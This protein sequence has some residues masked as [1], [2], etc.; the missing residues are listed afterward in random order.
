MLDWRLLRLEKGVMRRVAGSAALRWAAL[1][2]LAALMAA[3]AALA[4]GLL[5]PGAPARGIAGLAA[6]ACQGSP[7]RTALFCAA[8][9]AA[10]LALEHAAARLASSAASLVKRRAREDAYAKLLRL[11][12]SWE[13]TV[14][15][16]EA[17]KI[18]GEGAEKLE[19][20]VGRYAPQLLFALAAPLTLFALLVPVCWQSA[21]AML[22]CVP[23]MPLAI[24]A[25]MRSARREARAYWDSFV[26]LGG[27]F[28]DAVRGL[29][30]LKVY[31]SDGLRQKS[32]AQAGEAF[33]EATMALLRKQLGSVAVMEGVTY[34]GAAV[35]IAAA[36][37]QAASG[38]ASAPDALLAALLAVDFFMPMRRLG[39]YFHTAMGAG[40]AIDSLF[41]L[42]D[43]PEPARGERV[44]DP[45]D[46]GFVCEGVGYAYPDGRAGLRGASIEAPAGSYIGVTG[47]SGAGKSTLA[48]VLSGRLAG[49]TGS[50]RVGGVEL[51]DL[52]PE[53]LHET[54]TYVSRRSRVFKG[55]LRSNLE[56]GRADATDAEMWT[57]LHRCRLDAFAVLY[58]GLDTPVEEG[59]SN[60][61]GGQRQR[62][63]MARA[64]LHDTPVY[65]LDE[66]T[67]N[68]DAASEK[69][70]LEFVQ[71]LSITKTVVVISHRLAAIKWADRIYVLQD[72]AVAESGTHVGLI[73]AGGTYRRLWESQHG[74]E[75]FA[76]KAEGGILRS[77]QEE[78][79]PKPELD[80]VASVIARMPAKMAAVMQSAVELMPVR[81]FIA[82]SE[83][84]QRGGHP[85][86]I[87][88]GDGD[89]GS[90]GAAGGATEPGGRP[91]E[92]QPRK[93]LPAAPPRR[94]ALAV[95]AGL[96]RQTGEQLPR[97]AL[98]VALGSLA[99]LAA[100]GIGALAAVGLAGAEGA[101][102]AAPLAAACAGMVACGLAR[103]LLRYGERLLT[104]DQTFRTLALLRDRAFGA[105]RR[106]APAKLESRGSGDLVS[107]LTSDIDL[108]EAFYSRAAAPAGVAVV[109]F[110]A[111]TAAVCAV[112]PAL[113]LLAAGSLLLVGAVAPAL[114]ARS[115]DAPGRRLRERAV[116][117]GA[118]ISESLD[119][120]P[121]IIQFGWADGRLEDM[122][123]RMGALSG[124][125][126][127]IARR[128]SL[129][130]ALGAA[131]PPACLAAEA[132]LA[133]SLAASGALGAGQ[134]ALCVLM[135]AFSFGP[136][137][138]LAGLGASLH[139]TVAAGA[140]VLDLLDEE[141]ETPEVPDG[142]GE[143]LGSADAWPE[144]A[145]ARGVS[146]AYAGGG[147]VLSGVDVEVPLG[148]VVRVIGPSG[149][150]KSTL[151]KLLMRF[152]DADEGV[153]AVGGRD[154]RRVETSSLRA[155]ECSM[156]Q[157]TYLFAGTLRENLL[158]ARP[159]AAEAELL[160]AVAKA[161]LDEF[162]RRLP[163]GLDTPLGPGAVSD[164]ELQRI[165]LARMFLHGAPL[166]LLDEPTS[167]LDSLNESAVLNSIAENRAGRTVVIVS[168]RPSAAAIADRTYVIDG[169]RAS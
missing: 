100:M 158:V 106:L 140:R 107:L 75:E 123:S 21:A 10:M 146:F 20:Y 57:A 163:R 110:A 27:M 68:I 49:Y 25:V 119:G 133:A 50:V 41:K 98:A 72:G 113:G 127:R 37:A 32:L 118:F 13:E 35:G 96:M 89:A 105:M 152:W 11:G 36:L 124:D 142:Q 14:S 125:E 167:N 145:S 154:V 87:P 28:L 111:C 53:S 114:A 74:L 149:S 122:R 62:L 138:D 104:H 63:C 67:S 64:L 162:V 134:A 128:A 136:A 150:G 93:P 86:W 132:V 65:I 61:S 33:R 99:A 3:V 109:A 155:A 6:A 60:L 12:P 23:L 82:M 84:R 91:A 102:P 54:V 165:G 22:A 1:L 34:G 59:G 29:V 51:R 8:C 44:A 156:T 70:L 83:G 77:S 164:G 117:M 121:D 18:L 79:A 80:R 43:A 26:D 39:S 16:A 42:L 94:S 47:P 24:V 71:E 85:S 160:D 78:P 73:R 95:A 88:I 58:Q 131:L 101:S 2:A 90:G 147:P 120:L 157:D 143:R 166:M 15:A 48:G 115:L 92:E 108:L 46:A 97:L 9:A 129:S 45:A 112:S 141:P 19:M 7:A 30:T 144:G 66:A 31:S 161:S 153:V 52:S 5:D 137:R 56:L 38:A 40:P 159:Q 126:G 69:A 148:S 55:T 4:G 135:L 139:Q 103:G 116:A 151:L 81:D 130:G 168:H 17:S 169:G 76:R